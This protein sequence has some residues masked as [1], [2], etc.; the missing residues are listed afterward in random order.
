MSLLQYRSHP[1][2]LIGSTRADESMGIV[3]AIVSAYDVVDSWGTRFVYGAFQ[4]YDKKNSPHDDDLP[5]VVWSHDPMRFV[6]R[7]LETEELPAGDSSLPERSKPHG[8]WYVKSAFALKTR[9][10]A[11]L[12]E[13]MTFGSVTQWSHGFDPIEEQAGTDGVHEFTRVKV[14]E[15]SPVL[16]PA[17]EATSTV[18]IRSRFGA[19]DIKQKIETLATELDMLRQHATSYAD[20]RSREGRP[21]SDDVLDAWH[22]LAG[23]SREIDSV[24]ATVPVRTLAR[25]FQSLRRELEQQGIIT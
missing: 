3:E 16:A 15:V 24:L 10:G 20:M 18:G 21:L 13:H 14:I 7:V 9:D 12:Y 19:L 25:G 17:N 2:T 11:D 6:G 4:D 22:R 5:R 23:L 1:A 8:G